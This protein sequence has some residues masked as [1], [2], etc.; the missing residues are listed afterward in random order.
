MYAVKKVKLV[1]NQLVIDRSNKATR[2]FL[3]LLPVIAY[4]K[5]LLFEASLLLRVILGRQQRI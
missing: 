2:E 3:S 4:G 5:T 1:N